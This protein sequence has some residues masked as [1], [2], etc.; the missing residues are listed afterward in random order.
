[1]DWYVHW[2]QVM[3]YS[4]LVP[5]IGTGTPVLSTYLYTILV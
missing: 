5:E 3:E 1:M 4:A 2:Y